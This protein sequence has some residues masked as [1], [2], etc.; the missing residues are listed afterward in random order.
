MPTLKRRARRVSWINN[1]KKIKD[2]PPPDQGDMIIMIT[3]AYSLSHVWCKL[4]VKWRGR[5][6]TTTTAKR[7]EEGGQSRSKR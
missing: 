5:E 4:L 1:G 3:E 6:P 2:G 7:G